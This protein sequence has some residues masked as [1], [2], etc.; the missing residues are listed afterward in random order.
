MGAWGSG[1]FSNDLSADVRGDFR[2]M[3]EDGLSSE[4]AT[5]RILIEYQHAVDDVDDRTSFWTGL[6]AVQ[7]ELGRLLPQVRDRAVEIIDSGGDLDLWAETG[8]TG[9][10]QAAL[11]KL[12]RQLLGPQKTPVKVK[13]PAKILSPVEAGQTVAWRLPD[14]RDALLKVLTVKVW[15]QGS[16]PILEVV[17]AAGR[18]YREERDGV[19]QP[20]RYEVIEGRRAGLP[21]PEDL[22]VLKRGKPLDVDHP[23]ISMGWGALAITCKRLLDDP[24][25]KPRRGWGIG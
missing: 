14:G 6:A 16:Y 3:L 11:E 22:R 19:R 18:P 21:H 4:E 25:A 9:A 10:R 17:D 13:P 2:E 23:N 7:F 15:R 20:A 5:A 8:P 1:I 12:K 24:G